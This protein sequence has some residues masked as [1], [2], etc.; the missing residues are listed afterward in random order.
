VGIQ[1]ADKEKYQ[2]VSST[3]AYVYKPV[4]VFPLDKSDLKVVQIKAHF[5]SSFALCSNGKVYSWG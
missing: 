4:L 2:H 5:N 3:R 1:D